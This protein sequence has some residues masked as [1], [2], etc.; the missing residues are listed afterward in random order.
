[1][2]KGKIGWRQQGKAQEAG[3]V[4]F[5]DRIRNESWWIVAS[6][7][8]GSG[9]MGFVLARE[10]D[11]NKSA[12]AIESNL[13]DKADAWTETLTKQ[14]VVSVLCKKRPLLP[15]KVPT[16]RLHATRFWKAGIFTKGT[17]DYS[18]W[19]HGL[20]ASANE[21]AG[22][23]FGR[24]TTACDINEPP[25]GCDVHRFELWLQW[26]PCALSWLSL[27]RSEDPIVRN[28]CPCMQ[29]TYRSIRF[30]SVSAW[31]SSWWCRSRIDKASDNQKDLRSWRPPPLDPSVAKSPISDVRSEWHVYHMRIDISSLFPIINGDS[32][33]K[34][35]WNPLSVPYSDDHYDNPEPITYPSSPIP[36]EETWV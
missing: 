16:R 9:M 29:S 25:I 5:W 26:M 17:L 2:N 30:L 19:V 15:Q 32:D 27:K 23:G 34:G 28:V 12:S 11:L 1:M 24:P 22:N 7:G 13:H 20:S 4:W 8:F 36:Y 21:D 35:E 31:R 14:N 33:C 6:N 18:H 3:R 10:S